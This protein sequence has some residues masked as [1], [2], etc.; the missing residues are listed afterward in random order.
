MTATNTNATKG[1]DNVKRSMNKLGRES[2]STNKKMSGLFSSMRKNNN[3]FTNLTKDA[4]RASTGMKNLGKSFNVAQI[5]ATAFFVKLSLERFGALSQ[6]AMD[7]I[8]TNNLFTVSMGEAVEVGEEYV[9]TL[10]EVVGLDTTNLKSAVGTFALLSRSM[11]LNAE[12]S[13]K[14]STNMASLALDLSSLTNVPINQVFQDLRSGLLGQSETVYKYGIDVTEAALKSEALALGI[15]KSV[16][17]MGQGEKLALRYNVMLRQTGIAQGDLARTLETPANQLRIVQERIV[18]LGRALGSVFI[19]VIGRVLPYLN[20]FLTVLTE[21]VQR[22]ALLAGFDP[23]EG[24]GT[25]LSNNIQGVTEDVEELGNAIKG[26]LAGFDELNTIGQSSSSSSGTSGS[27][28]E[29]ISLSEYEGLLT[30]VKTRSSEIAEQMR[31][32]W[33]D[34][35][36]GKTFEELGVKMREFGTIAQ[37]LLDI[38]GPVV[39]LFA[40]Q[41]Y[42]GLLTVLDSIGTAIGNTDFTN[43]TKSI[44]ELFASFYDLSEV[45]IDTLVTF[46]EDVLAPLGKWT[47]E[48]A[49]PNILDAISTAF[50]SISKINFDPFMEALG[51]MVEPLTDIGSMAIEGFDWL[52]NK[53]LIPVSGWAIESLFPKVIDVLSIALSALTGVLNTAKPVLSWLWDN[54]LVPLSNYVGTMYIDFL[55]DLTESMTFVKNVIIDFKDQV[56]IWGTTL[57]NVLREN[58]LS[59]EEF[60]TKMTTLVETLLLKLLAKFFTYKVK[61]DGVLSDI[62]EGFRTAINSIK[63]F[64][65]GLIT[66]IA[67]AIKAVKDF[68]KLDSPSVKI[69]TSYD[70]P[71]YSTGFGAQQYANG[72]TLSRGQIFEAGEGGKAELIGNY[73]GRSTVMPLENSGFVEAMYSAV[74]SAVSQGSSGSSGIEK[75][76]VSIGGETFANAVVKS[77][78][79]QNMRYGGGRLN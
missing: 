44:G 56:I 42:E 6:S 75:V 70:N 17:N 27:V 55:D 3:R 58:R 37:Y 59:F 32:D 41:K 15:S 20:A 30:Q 35:G 22:L 16:R 61:F 78:N 8:E 5:A 39:E 69:N 40:I 54:F 76:E 52:L 49:V 1:I 2:K 13:A 46:V 66:K 72:G 71:M 51:G 67:E 53:F 34:L 28:L 79:K 65:D 25:G 33:A 7:M 64:W 18:S 31:A 45:G 73:G 21:I 4:N 77:V 24:G 11:G 48:D 60:K 23:D 26:S 74:Y 38:Y 43:L 14:V 62:K 47:I 9:D 29:D 36:L 19:P 50:D 57:A 68:F 10:N 63:V 12:Q